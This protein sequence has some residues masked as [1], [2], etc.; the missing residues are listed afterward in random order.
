M[1]EGRSEVV[2]Y[3][4]GLLLL[5]GIPALI[6]AIVGFYYL[7]KKPEFCVDALL[8]RDAIVKELN[9]AQDLPF[10]FQENNC[11]FGWGQNPNADRHI[12]LRVTSTDASWAV[13]DTLKRSGIS[14]MDSV[15]AELVRMG[16]QESASKSS[17]TSIF[18]IPLPD[19]AAR[20]E[21]AANNHLKEI[22]GECRRFMRHSNRPSAVI[23][24]VEI[25]GY[26]IN[27][28]PTACVAEIQLDEIISGASERP[29][30]FR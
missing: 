2:R 3:V 14:I 17:G 27:E 12:L 28:Q 26:M 9:Q 13:G 1:G 23:I 10:S 24:R 11:Y 18:D 4:G 19:A 16:Y 15:E 5:L 29:A 6:A 20:A 8:F 25:K 21:R 30:L 7:Q 22:R